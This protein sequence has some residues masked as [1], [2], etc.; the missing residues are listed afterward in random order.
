MLHIQGSWDGH[1]IDHSAS[2]V[3]LENPQVSRE[4]IALTDDDHIE[5][6][7]V[8]YD[9]YGDGQEHEEEQEIEP[10]ENQSASEPGET[11]Q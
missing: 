11:V 7:P 2:V 1:S 9:S 5:E 3:I 10:L 6:E 4:F 8:G